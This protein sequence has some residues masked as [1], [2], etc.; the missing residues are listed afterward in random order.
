MI[1]YM[2]NLESY[3]WSKKSLEYFDTIDDL[4][5]FVVDHRNKVCRYVGRKVLYRT[6]DVKLISDRDVLM[7]W[8][9]YHNVVLDGRT[10][11][12]CGE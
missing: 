4:K 1:R 7:G 11:G 10:E 8:T 2:P 9:N 6:S 12:F 5:E 3:L